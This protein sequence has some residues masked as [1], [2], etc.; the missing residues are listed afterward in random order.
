MPEEAEMA[1]RAIL[2]WI[3]RTRQGQAKNVIFPDHLKTGP[4]PPWSGERGFVFTGAQLYQH[5]A[6][7]DDPW[8]TTTSGRLDFE[9]PLGRRAYV[10]Y[11]ARYH[12]SEKGLVIED[13]RVKSMYSQ[14]PEP[15]M[16]V[17]PAEALPSDARRYPGTYGGLLQFVAARAVDPHKRA[18]IRRDERNY[19]IFVFFLDQASPSA[20]LEVKLS[21]RASTIYGYNESTRYLDYGGWIVGFVAGRVT[22]FAGGS[23]PP[24]YVKAVFTPGEEV[25]FLRRTPKLVGAFHISGPSS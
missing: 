17:V 3:T 8:K 9:G 16:F 2:G 25:P 11:N 1:A 12:S 21:D 15:I 19:V 20:N 18:S 7:V 4:A 13:A 6:S 5:G 22:L 23:S 10:S 14:F 24:L